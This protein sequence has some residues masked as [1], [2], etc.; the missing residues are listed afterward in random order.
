MLPL[1]GGPTFSSGYYSMMNP[2]YT[3][4]TWP[5][6]QPFAPGCSLDCGRCA[7]TG[8]SIQLLYFPPG[9]T[10]HPETAQ[11]VA[12]T[13]GTVLTSPTYYISFESI[14]ASDV[15]S[16]VG[17]TLTSLILPIPTDEP[18]ST[19]FGS[20]MACDAQRQLHPWR[21]QY[22]IG[23]AAM[24]VSD[25][26]HESVPY[27]IYTSQPYCATQMIGPSGCIPVS[28]PTTLPYRPLIVLSS[29]L[30]NT[31]D[32]A[33]AS[34]S[35]DLRG[36][37]DP[38]KALQPA[39]AIVLPTVAGPS[40][41]T[42]AIPASGPAG[43]TSDPTALPEQD[44]PTPIQTPVNPPK[45]TSPSAEAPNPTPDHPQTV[46]NP[47]P[48]DPPTQ[49]PA[50]VK[51]YK[52]TSNDPPPVTS[53]RTSAD[54]AGALISLIAD[55]SSGGVSNPAAATNIKTTVSGGIAA[56]PPPA[57]DPARPPTEPSDN[58][59][60]PPSDPAISDGA[61][62]AGGN[63]DPSQPAIPSGDAGQVVNHDPAVISVGSQLVTATPGQPLVVAGT[64]IAP[65]AAVTV[66]GHTLSS[67]SVGLIVDG[68]PVLAPPN[69]GG[70]APAVTFTIGSQTLTAS[71]GDAAD[72]SAVVVAGTTLTPGGSATT[73]NGAV[74]SAGSAGL[75]IDGTRTVGLPNGGLGPAG[76]ASQAILTLGSSTVTAVLA[77]GIGNAIVI[78]GTTVVPGG[79]AIT[80]DGTRLS[81]GTAGLVI[82]GTQ[83]IPRSAFDPAPTAAAASQAVFTLGSDIITAFV[84]PGAV[85]TIVVD[86]TTLSAGGSAITVD[87]TRLSAG[88]AG[89]VIGG[90]QTIPVADIGSATA[91]A[92]GLQTVLTIGSS[93]ITATLPSR[94]GNTIVVDG[95]TLSPGGSTI[96]VDGTVLSIGTAGLVV[97]GTQTIP[98]ASMGS[99]TTSSN[100]LQT[101]LI[102]GSST[103]TA[104]LPFGT[105]N[106]I[107]VDGTTL[108]P[109]GSAIT[110]DDTELSAGT[111]GLVAGGTRTVAL[112]ATTGGSQTTDRTVTSSPTTPAA[113]D[114]GSTSE[115]AQSDG[116]R[117]SIAYRGW[118]CVLMGMW[119]LLLGA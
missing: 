87:G 89:L 73:I 90:T 58:P 29:Q 44:D 74:V 24:N 23:T 39:T 94:S 37:Y 93:T 115:S 97:G 92:A 96:T 76:V 25:L 105:G 22:V 45:P 6:S 49:I 10:P 38:P 53:P 112:T 51:A 3:G 35:L 27:S 19:L 79:S 114:P 70:Q 20:T 48:E 15:C 17:S 68:T 98:F 5:A 102:I 41:T 84:P 110:V 67:G 63:G 66:D 9:M 43:A 88:T 26:L 113:T 16:G 119:A 85:A 13:L 18:L 103:I 83:T 47:I 28:C 56:Q 12:T 117:P 4:W 77:A 118:L 1:A 30:L 59:A 55:L 52:T 100:A 54:P 101:V 106:I 107:V 46:V 32:P 91:A 33:W 21:K 86:G 64:T 82:A 69:S 99:A 111:A 72:P 108:S 78:D 14:Y 75:V 40:P 34:C 42:S 62:V 50:P 81:A 95:T 2:A 61:P 8:G 109:G 36:L 116:Q 57:G 31:L 11:V 60:D 80:V 71:A 65:N 7:V 104:T